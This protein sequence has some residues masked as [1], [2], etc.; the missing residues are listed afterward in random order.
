M[1]SGTSWRAL[2]KRVP[3]LGT[4]TSSTAQINAPTPK[5][6]FP[7]ALYKDPT[8]RIRSRDW[9]TRVVSHSSVCASLP[10]ASSCVVSLLLC[11]CVCF[12]R[13]FCCQ[14][15]RNVFAIAKPSF[16][17]EL[18]LCGTTSSLCVRCCA[19]PMRRSLWL[20]HDSAQHATDCF[21]GS[22]LGGF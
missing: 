20:L 15:N 5:S 6:R 21:Y 2:Q 16:C 13:L 4:T 18:S 8:V 22:N 1:A 12:L 19:F 9:G 7:V 10:L 11:F 17:C 3:T 14:I